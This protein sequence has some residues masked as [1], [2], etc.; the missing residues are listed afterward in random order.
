MGRMNEKG[1]VQTS[2]IDTICIVCAM[3][4]ANKTTLLKHIEDVHPGWVEGELK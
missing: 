3:G 4:T 1:Y 2:Y